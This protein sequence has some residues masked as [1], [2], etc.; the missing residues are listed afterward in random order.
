MKCVCLL[1]L[2]ALAAPSFQADVLNLSSWGRSASSSPTRCRSDQF[3]CRTGECI[4]KSY[5]C[6]GDRDCPGGEDERNC[7]RVGGTTARLRP[8][9][10]PDDET[11]TSVEF[12]CGRGGAGRYGRCIPNSPTF[13]CD[14]VNDCTNGADERNCRFSQTTERPAPGCKAGE[15]RCSSGRCLRPQ[16]VCDG[17]QDCSDGAD[18]RNCGRT[19]A[20]SPTTAARRPLSPQRQTSGGTTLQLKPHYVNGLKVVASRSAQQWSKSAP[21]KEAC[22]QLCADRSKCKLVSYDKIGKNCIAYGE[23]AS[24]R[25]AFDENFTSYGQWTETATRYQ[26]KSFTGASDI[27]YD[28]QPI[29]DWLKIT[30][31]EQVCMQVCHIHPQCDLALFNTKTNKCELKKKGSRGIIPVS[32][33]NYIGISIDE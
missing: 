21:T 19:P 6:D 20:R 4:N 1:L 17:D 24:A 22:A 12:D 26:G 10:G 5:Q 27:T 33:S 13:I 29:A 9:A 16:W 25:F 2:A 11:C 32:N 23:D 7:V 31:T 14:G 15:F 18:E 3:Q 8:N 30:W 28:G